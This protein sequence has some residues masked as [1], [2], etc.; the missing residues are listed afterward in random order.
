MIGLLP[1]DSSLQSGKYAIDHP[2]GRGGFGVT[3]WAHQQGLGRLVA[4][5]EYFPPHQAYRDSA[6]GKMIPLDESFQ[7]GLKRFANEGRLLAKLNHPNVVLVHD[8]FEEYG[9]AYLVMEM[10]IGRTLRDELAAF[11]GK[12][13]AE[14]RVRELMEQLV[15]ALEAVHRNEIYHLDIKPENVMVRAENDSAVLV[16]FGAAR[17]VGFTSS[18]SQ[19]HTWEYAPLEIIVGAS[20]DQIGAHSDVF[21]LG[22]M[23]H[24][25]LTGELP[26]PA[27]SRA[28][29]DGWQPAT[30]PE[31]WRRIVV[32]ALVLDWEQRPRTVREWWESMTRKKARPS[33]KTPLWNEFEF[34]TLSLNETGTVAVP[35]RKRAKCYTEEISAGVKLEMVKLPAG[36]F[37]MGSPEPENIFT[38]DLTRH[39]HP[40]HEV[41]VKGFCMAKYPVTVEQWEAVARLPKVNRELHEFLSG[42]DDSRQPAVRITRSAAM[43]FCAR[44]SKKT[45]REYRLPSEAEW[46]YACRAG[47]TSPF[48]F[49]ETITPEMANFQP[50]APEK[51]DRPITKGQP[52]STGDLRVANGFGLYGMHGG[53]WEWCEDVWHEN[54]YGDAPNDGSVWLTGGDEEYRVVRGGGWDD[55]PDR[56]RAAFRKR[57]APEIE[58]DD[59]GLRVVCT[60]LEPG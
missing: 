58:N 19:P 42:F 20:S 23:L 27:L 32:E 18:A 54:Y 9:T 44:L 56:C 28:A 8:S 50:A 12:G 51:K 57:L 35:M 40:L 43:E 53:V 25:L 16:D 7:R 29:K 6:S 4:I 17:Q 22:M 38:P 55:P 41:H 26:P 13:L 39:E 31:S 48:A 10:I 11:A 49:G 59:V 5:K 60:L 45:G 36:E 46:E 52:V 3:Y 33:A 14:L 34:K 24:E 21:E 30:L 15:N 47:T 2:H 37:Q 1:F